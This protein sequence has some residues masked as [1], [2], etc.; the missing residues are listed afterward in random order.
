MVFKSTPAAAREPGAAPD[1]DYRVEIEAS[2]RRVRAVFNTETI[3]DSAAMLLV[4]ETRHLP[5]YYFPREDVDMAALTRTDYRSHCPYK[6]KASYWTIA[7]G[8]RVAENAVWSYEDPLPSVPGLENAM[9]FYWDKVDRWYEEDE[10]VF[11]HPRDP[12]HR[13]DVVESRRPVAVVLGGATVAETTRARF[14]FETGLPTRYYIP[15]ADV[16]A[17]LL[18]PSPTTT[19]C[20]YK[21]IASYH[22]VRIGERVF[23]DI[24]WFYPEPI[25]ECPRI[26]DY[27]C[28]YNERVD[29]ILVDGVPVA[30]PR[31]KWSTD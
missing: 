14:L 21:G 20:P 12:Y 25:P 23:E 22:S 11:V 2:P 17:D 6:G 19:R 1:P 27:L 15:A 4:Y 8:D 10:E 16:R 29:A 18:E 28:F 9:A 26:K 31:T 7:V 13:V 24:A 5:V 3:A 30:R